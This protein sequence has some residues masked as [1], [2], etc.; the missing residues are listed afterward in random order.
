MRS[1]DIV[2]KNIKYLTKKRD[3]ANALRIIDQQLKSNPYDYQLLT[4]KAMVY[5]RSGAL[6]D[7]LDIVYDVLSHEIDNETKI[8]AYEVAGTA[9]EAIGDF[10]D[11]ILD[12]KA[13][14]ELTPGINV[15]SVTALSRLF[16][17]TGKKDEA[18]ESLDEY[19]E[20][21][22]TPFNVSRA[23]IHYYEGEY[24][25][26]LESLSLA[27][28]KPAYKESRSEFDKIYIQALIK[29]KENKVDEALELYNR[30]LKQSNNTMSVYWDT[31]YQTAR[32]YYNRLEEEK[33]IRICE[34]IISSCRK[35]RDYVCATNLLATIYIYRNDLD[36]AKEVYEKCAMENPK[37]VGQARIAILNGNYDEALEKLKSV[38]EVEYE[39]AFLRDYY[40][41]VILFKKGEYDAFKE[42]YDKC[43]KVKTDDTLEYIQELDKM[44][45]TLTIERSL[46]HNFG[47]TYENYQIMNYD[48]ILTLEHMQESNEIEDI[49][50]IYS[51][52]ADYLENPINEGVYDKYIIELKKIGYSDTRRN[53]CVT[54][55]AGTKNII[56]I[57]KS[58]DYVPD[59][60]F[61]VNTPVK[62]KLSPIDKFNKK[63]GM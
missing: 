42:L 54:C 9:H 57:H 41:A 34:D 10:E 33:A 2:M 39:K 19:K 17:K 3:Y 25:K 53:I 4:Y 24:D 50:E 46:P 27:V 11:A 48:P 29:E 36:K 61:K 47:L 31:R 15:K 43:V 12:R 21:N 14:I 18:L 23:Y 37:R 35:Y 59:K 49:K 26:A 44:L 51:M 8:F 56:D 28:I 63:Y 32:I 40:Q 13:A 60:N 1:D 58:S 30:I 6:S 55:I 5:N 52:I 62:Q 16:Y 45:L 38:D 22:L 20:S 7:A